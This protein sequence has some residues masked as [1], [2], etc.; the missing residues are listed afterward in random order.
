MYI[1]LKAHA[2]KLMANLS[3]LYLLAL[4]VIGLPYVV[5]LYADI[6]AALAVFVVSQILLIIAWKRAN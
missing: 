4:L 5:F 6:R 2:G 3:D 1:R